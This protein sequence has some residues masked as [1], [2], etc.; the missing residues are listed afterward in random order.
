MNRI[1]QTA[2]IAFVAMAVGISQGARNP[3]S[4]APVGST[5]QA[6]AVS[7]LAPLAGQSLA[8]DFVQVRYELLRPALSDEPTFLVQLDAADPVSTSESSYT[9]SDL[10]PGLHTVRVTLVD[11][12]KT[13]VQGGTATV[14]FEIS[15]SSKPAAGQ[16][17]RS[18]NPSLSLA[19]IEPPA[20]IP[21][22]LLAHGDLKFPVAGSPLPLLSLVG[23][24]LL[25]GG[26]ART[27]RAR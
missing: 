20:P 1:R 3:Q 2:L 6:P 25:I 22:E 11:A 21:P 7:I 5:S 12:N 17:P 15:A 9:F 8:V 4:T 24:G 19:G 27:M 16:G 23:F 14:Q 26:V 10:Q 13:P 18:A